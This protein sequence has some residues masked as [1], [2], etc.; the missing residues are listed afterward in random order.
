MPALI[1]YT[2]G[3]EAGPVTCRTIRGE[4][5]DMVKGGAGVYE[6]KRLYGAKFS[7]SSS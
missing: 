3:G 4:A 5:I 6:L 7:L 1:V 2:L